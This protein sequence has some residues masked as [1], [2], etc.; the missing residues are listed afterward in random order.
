MKELVKDNKINIAEIV[1]ETI[2]NINSRS[3]NITGCDIDC[4]LIQ[5]SNFRNNPKSEKGRSRLSV[6]DWC[7]QEDFNHRC[8]YNILQ[9][10][11]EDE[12][13]DGLRWFEK[14]NDSSYFN[15]TM[16]GIIDIYGNKDTI[17]TPVIT[18]AEGSIYLD[19]THT[20]FDEVIAEIKNHPLFKDCGGYNEDLKS[21]KMLFSRNEL[22]LAEDAGIKLGTQRIKNEK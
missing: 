5:V 18:V 16:K 8:V 3:E 7:K 14:T 11:D 20:Y 2:R 17:N 10:G 6:K 22:K 9:N 13:I 1:A 19:E 15:M 4:T 21:K 12:G